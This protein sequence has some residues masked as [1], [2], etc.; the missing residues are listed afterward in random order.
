MKSL[1]KIFTI[2]PRRQ[3]WACVGIAGMMLVGA[4]LE[5][6][7]IGAIF[8]LI[9]VM[10]QPEYLAEH[11]KEAAF[12][13]W[14]GVSTHV[15]FIIFCAAGL[16]GLYVGKNLYLAFQARVQICFVMRQQIAYAE[17]LFASY[18]AKP[19]LYHIKY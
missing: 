12:A 2:L 10:G 7:G 4:M 9:S 18:L 19:Y 13:S 17:A 3:R 5:A 16:A 1:F 11:P 14:L 15:G 8:P 6:I